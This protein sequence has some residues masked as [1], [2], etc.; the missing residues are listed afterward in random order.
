MLHRRTFLTGMLAG[1][2]APAIVRPT[3]L[4]PIK[5]LLDDV[6]MQFTPYPLNSIA[7]DLNEEV[8]LRMLMR[9]RE[10]L[11]PGLMEITSSYYNID[12]QWV[13][14]ETARSS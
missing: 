4:M 10:E 5:P 6:T 2:V 1:I 8:M 12:D 13:L 9:V 3:S 11:L 14:R 7:E